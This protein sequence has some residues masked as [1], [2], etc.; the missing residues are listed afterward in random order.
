MDLIIILISLGALLF[1]GLRLY[2]A[3]G[4]REG[5]MEAPAPKKPAIDRPAEDA[6]PALVDAP[7]A[8]APALEGLEAIAQADRTFDPAAF[9]EGAKSAYGL[10]VAAFAE[11]DKDALKPLLA[12]K[13]YD[14]YVDAIDKRRA[15][16]ES[17][18]TEIE[19]VA[20]AEI[21]KAELTDGAARIG[22]RFTA[23]IAT[24]TR[25]KD[26]EV[27]SGDLNQLNTVREIWTFERKAASADPNWV[28]TRV[29]TA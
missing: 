23:D 2:S 28:L 19:R 13:V 8:D 27:I 24:E 15:A 6:A 4:R 18:T 22:I 12:P 11:G 1:F 25:G 16:G 20:R 9:V 5:H 7:T 26:G 17:L 29:E 21:A 10:I 3:L 14:R